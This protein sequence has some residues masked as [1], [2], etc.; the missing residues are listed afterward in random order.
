MLAQVDLA[1][2]AVGEDPAR[3]APD[4]DPRRHL[5]VGLVGPVDRELPGPAAVEVEGAEG[6]V[7]GLAE[8]TRG[9][10]VPPTPAGSPQYQ[11]IRLI[12][13]AA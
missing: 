12:T 4:V 11:L 10:T 7:V 5:A 1:F 9:S 3:R 2:L 8:K 13:W 6:G